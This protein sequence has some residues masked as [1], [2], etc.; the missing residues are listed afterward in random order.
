MATYTV[1]AYV[2][3]NV[4]WQDYEVEANNSVGA[5]DF[6]KRAYGAEQVAFANPKK[7]SFSF[8]KIGRAHV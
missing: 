4:G 7:E 5:R 2:N 3:S 8:N 1:R 6:V